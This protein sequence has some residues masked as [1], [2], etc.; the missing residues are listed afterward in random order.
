MQ[1]LRLQKALYLSS[2]AASSRASRMFSSGSQ[3]LYLGGGGRGGTGRGKG[4]RNQQWKGRKKERK[5]EK[6]KKWH[7]ERDPTF[8]PATMGTNSYKEPSPQQPLGCKIVQ[9]ADLLLRPAL[10]FYEIFHAPLQMQR[11]EK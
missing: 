3:V 1:W 7:R 10:P 8:L 4:I 6:K 2:K 9:T 5:I 11:E